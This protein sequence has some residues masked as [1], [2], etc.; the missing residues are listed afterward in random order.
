MANNT[1]QNQNDLG[2]IVR[3]SDIQKI[4]GISDATARRT[5]D[6]PKPI[7]LGQR[8]VGWLLSEL[9]EW[10]ESRPRGYLPPAGAAVAARR[11]ASK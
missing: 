5:P 7:Q 1:A 10:R 9:I 4:V 2:D 6:F 11:R 3:A 8:R